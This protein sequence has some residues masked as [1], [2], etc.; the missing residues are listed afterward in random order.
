MGQIK[1]PVDPFVEAIETSQGAYEGRALLI[2]ISTQAATDDDM[3]SRWLDD[4][5]SSEDPRIV[6]HL[7]SAPK[8]CALTDREAWAAAR[9]LGVIVNTALR[10]ARARAWGGTSRSGKISFNFAEVCV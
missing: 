2:A 9:G 3:F 10:L 4:A 7:Y 1:G 8:D 5:K 6:S